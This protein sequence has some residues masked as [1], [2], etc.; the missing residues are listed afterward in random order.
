MTPSMVAHAVATRRAEWERA[1]ENARI[2]DAA[3]AFDRDLRGGVIHH[4]IALHGRGATDHPNEV[5]VRHDHHWTLAIFRK[6]LRRYVD[7]IEGVSA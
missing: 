2:S 3:A 1:T 5:Q 7:T 6:A 4:L